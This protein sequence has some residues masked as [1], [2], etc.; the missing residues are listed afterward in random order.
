VTPGALARSTLVLLRWF[1][2]H[3]YTDWAP[4][5]DAVAW[6]SSFGRWSAWRRTALDGLTSAS[7][8]LEVG[9]GTGHLLA[10][11]QGRR[12]RSFGVDASRQMAA[13]TGRRLRK[14][15]LH[16]WAVRARAQA[17]PFRR[18][19]FGAAISTFPSEY[20]FD[21]AVL[22]E[23]HRVLVPGARLR[24]V[25]SARI[26]PR[27]LWER[28]SRALYDVTGQA[29]APQSK[30]LEPFRLAGFSPRYETVEV[31]GASVVHIVADG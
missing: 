29:P 13:I 2:R 28:L 23:I 15:G 3:L 22:K 10:E 14:R 9:F 26:L 19:G 7:D 6:L 17:L 11:A 20:I 27:F 24:V 1:F 21:P 8:V 30:W 18:G 31:P 4:T 25:I 16:V 12:M 5:Y